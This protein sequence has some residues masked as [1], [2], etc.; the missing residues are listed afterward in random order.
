VNSKKL[1]TF[2]HDALVDPSSAQVKYLRKQLESQ[3]LATTPEQVSAWFKTRLDNVSVMSGSASAHSQKAKVAETQAT[4]SPIAG[5]PVVQPTP[6]PKAA[7]GG[8]PTYWLIP[9][10]K[11][12]GVSAAGHLRAWLDKG[13]WGLGPNTPGRK[14]LR[15]GDHVA[16]YAAQSHEVMAHARIAGEATVPGSGQPSGDVVYKLPLTDISWLEPPI[17]LDSVK[18]ASLDAYAGKNP[19]GNWSFL[20]QTTRRLSEGDFYRLIGA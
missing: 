8:A 6:P 19:D 16:F 10:G 12:G 5:Y 9:A 17:K 7:S 11:Q 3:G 13:F 4:L 15:V 14:A 1:D 18:R 20:V 2:L